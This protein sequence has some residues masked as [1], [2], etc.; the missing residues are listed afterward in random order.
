[1]CL[2]GCLVTLAIP[3]DL[4]GSVVA[5]SREELRASKTPRGGRVLSEL[6]R[7]GFQ[8]D[9]QATRM[10]AASVCRRGHSCQFGLALGPCAR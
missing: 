10:F 1:M 4:K 9:S 7:C 2:V 5:V 8:R 3:T 6:I